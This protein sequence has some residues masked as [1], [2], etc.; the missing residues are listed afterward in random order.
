MKQFDTIVFDLG[1][2]LIDWNPEYVY[3]TIFN[4][5]EEVQWFLHN[6]TTGDW[7]EEQD[8]GKTLASATEELVAKFPEQEANIRAF[9]GRWE[10]MLAGPIEGTVEV[11]RELRNNTANKI[12]ALTNWSA[13][14]FPIAL[15]KYDFLHW[16]NG[17]LV[18]G[19]EMTRKP[20]MDIYEKLIERFSINPS[21]SIYIDDNKRN[22]YPAQELGMHTIHFNSP[23][24][25]R[26][27]LK[28]LRVL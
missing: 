17:R 19:E 11:F 12:Y 7:N 21:S 27:E 6:I 25:L 13:E 16:F 5:E 20:F 26:E 23:E 10:E 28:S 4:T 2:V 9:Y 22:L 1:G 18:S 8:A 24:Q 15:Q 14:T 3:R